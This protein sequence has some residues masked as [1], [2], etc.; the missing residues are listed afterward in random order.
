MNSINQMELQSIRHLNGFASNVCDKIT[1]YKTLT[2]DQNVV[3]NMEDVY[4]E[5]SQFKTQLSNVLG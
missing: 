2:F 4:N 5:L 3:K 1:Y